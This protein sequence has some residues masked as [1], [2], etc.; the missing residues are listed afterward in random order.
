MKTDKRNAGAAGSSARQ[1]GVIIGL[2]A[3]IV[4]VDRMMPR[5]FI[6]RGAE[7][8]LSV[9][10]VPADE[11]G[12]A[13]PFG[14]FDPET[15]PTLEQGL[16]TW[17]RSQTP[18]APGYVEQLY[19][20]G[21]R[22]RYAGQKD[23]EQRVVSIGYLALTHQEKI[24]T[25]EKVFWG[26]WYDY[27]PWEDWRQGCPPVID[28]AIAPGLARWIDDAAAKE[29]KSRRRARAALCFG[30]KASDWD[31]E[32]VLDRYELLYEAR[33]VHEAVRDKN[34]ESNTALV[35]GRSMLYDHRRI[36]ATA[37][38]RL[39]GKLKYR[40]VVFELMP[41]EFTLLELQKTVE[42][43]SGHAVH[44]QNFRRLVESSGMVEEIAGK[45]SAHAGGR[46]AALFR[47]RRDALLERPAPDQKR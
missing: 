43:I 1:S 9:G 47:F 14:P 31:D 10:I 19:T 36:L 12:D 40:P 32:K 45:K 8:A 24:R 20:F 23:D 4:S 33:L 17:V 44:K 7:H 13:L 26:G 22:G 18:I 6:V 11:E 21:N 37:M 35:P 38:S 42:A 29:E 28:A 25:S 39:R 15:H 3:V 41:E 16:R 34:L 5:V 27:F 2:S 46:P 30:A